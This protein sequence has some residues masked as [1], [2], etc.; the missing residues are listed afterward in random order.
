VGADT[1]YRAPE[2]LFQPD[3]LGLEYPGVHQCVYRSIMRADLDLRKTLY[4]QIV[5]AGGSTMFRGARLP[6]PRAL[7][8]LSHVDTRP[9]VTVSCHVGFGDRL[10][11]ELRKLAPRGTKLRIAADPQRKVLTW[12]GGCVCTRAARERGGESR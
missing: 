1:Q 6:S 11:E 4:S 10:L 5:L 2:I 8:A 7:L 3:L 12:A 9:W